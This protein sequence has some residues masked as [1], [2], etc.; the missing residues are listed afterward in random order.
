MISKTNVLVKTFEHYL[1]LTYSNKKTK[2]L[3]LSQVKKFL[4]QIGEN[5]SEPTEFTQEILDTYVI[6]LNSKNNTNPFYKGVCRAMFDCF[7]QEDKDGRD[8][9]RLKKKQNKSREVKL[10]NE[11]DW[12]T[13]EQVQ[14]LIDKTSTYM[15]LTIQMFWETALRKMELINLNLNT[16]EWGLDLKKREIWGIGKGGKAFRQSFS[17]QMADRLKIWLEECQDP[18]R[19]FIIFKE[20]GEPYKS[21]DHQYWYRLKRESDATGIK[22]PNGESVHAHSIRHGICRWLRQ[23]KK[24]QIEEIMKFARHSDPKT[25]AIYSHAT[26]EEVKKKLDKEVFDE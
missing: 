16:K 12:V 7:N 13:K 1:N 5:G 10:L 18:T 17:K 19:P 11:Y 22:L 2:E 15:S 20:T 26:F 6:Y 8:T 14:E 3:Y 24:W 21:Q 4:T 23:E 9:L 25:T